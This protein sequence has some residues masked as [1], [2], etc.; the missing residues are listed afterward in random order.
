MH[1][2]QYH[3]KKKETFLILYGKIQLNITFNKKRKKMIMR[4]GEVFT[5]ERGMVHEFKALSS[6][7]KS[8]AGLPILNSWNLHPHLFNCS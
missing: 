7:N 3:K 4:P 6:I 5:I 2:A 1:P 8:Y